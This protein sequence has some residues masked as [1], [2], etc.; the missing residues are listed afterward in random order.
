MRESKRLKICLVA[1]AGGHLSELLKLSECWDNHDVFSVT[2]TSVA[3]KSLSQFGKT[4][5]VGECNRQHLCKVISVVCRSLRPMFR[6]KPDI[7]I[8]TGAAAGLICSFLGKML[9]AKVIWIDS[10][11][12]VNRISLS[13]W[14]AQPIVG[15]LLVQWSKLA[16]KYKNCE[17]V[18]S[19]I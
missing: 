12:N 15:L 2:T 16:D 18:G 3:E 4:Y 9:G 11:A 19:V 6:E 10:I 17:H 8:S 13:G 7:V 5:V 1:S 14:L